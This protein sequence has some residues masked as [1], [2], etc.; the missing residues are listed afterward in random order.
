LLMKKQD[1]LL[2]RQFMQIRT[3]ISQVKE[4]HVT[5]MRGSP[6]YSL[7]ESPDAFSLPCSPMQTPTTP[8]ERARAASWA[9]LPGMTDFT[10]RSMT[11]VMMS[12]DKQRYYAAL[13]QSW[14]LELNDPRSPTEVPG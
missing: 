11:S 4:Q 3:T 2:M 13:S 1:K 5:A 14:Q 10:R 7:L 8:Y 9:C 6:S 12:P